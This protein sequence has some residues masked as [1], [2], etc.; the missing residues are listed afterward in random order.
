MTE[1]LNEDDN[2][3]RHLDPEDQR[4]ESVQLPGGEAVGDELEQ[5]KKSLAGFLG[6][7]NTTLKKAKTIYLRN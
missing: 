5:H 4:I 3:I 1:N 2:I 6:H 7:F